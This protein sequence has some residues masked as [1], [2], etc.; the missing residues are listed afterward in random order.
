MATITV[1][2]PRCQSE[3]VYRHGFSE[4]FP[5]PRLPLC[6]STRARSSKVRFLYKQNS[7]YCLIIELI[8]GC[9][10]YYFAINYD[11][12]SPGK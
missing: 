11:Q 12:L 9:S 4:P 3:L 6:L 8:F 1:H 7:I 5:L 2:C 10:N